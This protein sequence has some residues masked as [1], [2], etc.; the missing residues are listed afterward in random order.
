[1]TSFAPKT[2]KTGALKSL[3]ER[4]IL[5]CSTEELL[6]DELKHLKKV[7]CD[8]INFP[9]WVVR[10]V[11]NEVKKKHERSV[12]RNPIS[13]DNNITV[14]EIE[15]KRYLLILLYQGDRGNTLVKSLQK[16]LHNL[17]S[18]SYKHTSYMHREEA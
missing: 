11:M 4:T 13:I 8:K 16:I 7:F 2:W 14:K 9:K 5:I 18:K 12:I 6:N 10:N 1:M 3:I 15:Q 17:F